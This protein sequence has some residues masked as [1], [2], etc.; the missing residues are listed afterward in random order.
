MASRPPSARASSIRTQ[1][2]KQLPSGARRVVGKRSGS[3]WG[4]WALGG[5]L[6]FVLWLSA[7][8]A[9]LPDVSPLRT[10]NP[11]TTALMAQRAEEAL[12]AGKK[13]RVRQAWVSLGAVAPHVVDAVL[14]SEDA[15]FYQHGGVD[16]TEVENA[17]EQSVREA[18]LGRGASTLT[19]QLAKNLY[20]STDR[21]LLR[22]GKELL[23]AHRL[24]A[25][26][27]KQRILTLYVNV[28]E[29]GEGV[30]GIEAAARE[31]FGTSARALSVAQG[32]MLAGML[33]APRRWLP[34]QRPE[35]LRIR[36]GVI[37]GRMEREGRISGAQARE[38]QAE[39]SRF[40]GVP[41]APGSVA[42]ASTR[43][44]AGS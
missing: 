37:L 28:V 18:R 29:W 24:E 10:Q 5:W 17:L 36:A 35:A 44:P 33:P 26:L 40:F 19:Q 14:I 6:L 15:R 25:H 4:R 20:L 12:E 39:L 41:P 23:L 43:L 2:T 3:G 32:A 30:Y 22:K 21:S 42:E 11:R 31:H 38:A 16:W 1:K 9:R 7:G 13:P 8:Y 27:S 34:A